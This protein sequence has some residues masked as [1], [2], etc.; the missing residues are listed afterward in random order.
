MGKKD[1][2]IRKKILDGYGIDITKKEDNV[3]KLYSIKSSD[4]SGQELED[5]IATTRQK[6]EKSINGSNEKFAKRDQARLDNA[7]RYE[8]ILRDDRLRHELFAFYSGD[9]R[10][11]AGGDTGFAR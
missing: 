9:G 8:A 3:F 5:A 11:G 2:D 10:G 6:W 7:D 4:I 1:I